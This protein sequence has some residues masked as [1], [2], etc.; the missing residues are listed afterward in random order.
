MEQEQPTDGVKGVV[1]RRVN[2]REVFNHTSWFAIGVLTPD[3]RVLEI[4]KTMLDESD[5]P[6]EEVVGKPFVELPCWSH[7]VEAQ[8]RICQAIERAG[9]GEAVRM[10]I[11]TYPTREFYRDLDVTMMP[12]V[13]G[14]SKAKYLIYTSVD[15]TERKWLEEERYAFIDS[16][17]DLCWMASLD[18][19]IQYLNKQWHTSTRT[20]SDQ[21]QED[22]WSQ[23]IHP[24][25]RQP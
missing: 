12:F 22:A 19:S 2:Y 8:E 14:D 3:G 25:D 7:S 21:I 11:R 18:G 16:I 10:D 15:I 1:Q 23:S 24:D 6:F 20:S 4:S 9:R 5:L 17:P 13:T